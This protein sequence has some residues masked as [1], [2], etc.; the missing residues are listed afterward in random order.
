MKNKTKEKRNF[1]EDW[2]HKP[3]ENK[4]TSRKCKLCKRAI[5]SW[6]KS[7]VCSGCQS[8]PVREAIKKGL[9]KI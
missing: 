6:N 5:R 3:M 4:I 2:G 7:G 1:T 9:I 8:M